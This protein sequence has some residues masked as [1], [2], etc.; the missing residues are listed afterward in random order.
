[1]AETHHNGEQW[2]S[3]SSGT[4]AGSSMSD[5]ASGAMDQARDM[6]NKAV[7]AAG[8]AQ[9][10]ASDTVRQYPLSTMVA[11]AGVSFA[12]GALWKA[13]TFTP[14]TGLH[15]YMDRLNGTLSDAWNELPSRRSYWR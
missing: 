5:M 6:G 9:R 2:G 15:R 3:K 13:G 4:S 11:V 8:E 7:D 10:M 12:L 14:R 1:M